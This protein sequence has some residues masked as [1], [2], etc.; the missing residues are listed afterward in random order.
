MKSKIEKAQDRLASV[1]TDAQRWD[2]IADTKTEQL[3]A[4]RTGAGESVLEA[5][6]DD[7][8]LAVGQV[9]GQLRDLRVEVE[10]SEM[11]A[12]TARAKIVGA[13][14]DVWNIEAADLRGQAAKIYKA[15][16]KREV[17]TKTMLAELAAWEGVDY[18]VESPAANSLGVVDSGGNVG[19]PITVLVP[20]SKTDMMRCE[21]RDLELQADLLEK[22]Q[23][24]A[25]GEVHGHSLNDII[26]LVAQAEQDLTRTPNRRT[27]RAWADT[28]TSKAEAALARMSG[29]NRA[30]H[31]LRYDL[32]W[33]DG[34]ID[35]AMSNVRVAQIGRV[36]AGSVDELID[37]VKARKLRGHGI[38][39]A[40]SRIRAWADRHAPKTT[41]RHGV[42]YDLTWVD[43]YIDESRSQVISAKRVDIPA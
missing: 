13:Q 17:K 42:E 2:D 1:V 31:E 20:T 10:A 19:A 3:T 9:A 8:D 41:G 32:V 23:L 7:P 18:A 12:S 21:A 37:G 4:L 28:T 43:G 36:R 16:D 15:A 33:R 22:K 39:G 14:R 6:T 30:V 34:A 26:A 27:I 24:P 38:Q 29:E 25:G 11:A 40:P 35:P 5:A